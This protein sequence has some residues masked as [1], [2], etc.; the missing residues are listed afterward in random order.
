MI[1]ALPNHADVTGAP[2]R[3]V[4]VPA[5]LVTLSQLYMSVEKMIDDHARDMLND[6]PILD[7]R[8]V[9]YL[10]VGNLCACMHFCLEESCCNK[11]VALSKYICQRC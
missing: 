6:R 2:R 7:F 5:L 10:A 3:T 1:F 9:S 4:G 11:N 8:F